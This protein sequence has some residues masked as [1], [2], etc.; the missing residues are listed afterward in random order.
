MKNLP[1]IALVLL[2]VIILIACSNKAKQEEYKILPAN[3]IG[4]LL[5][6]QPWI[7]LVDVRTYAE[8]E[9][10]YIEK[11]INL[12]L[13]TLESSA[14]KHLPD[15][16]QTIIVYCKT[17]KR[18]QVAVSDL[19]SLGYTDIIELEGGLDSWKGLLVKEE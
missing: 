11:A 13:D 16:E 3:E 17:G 4:I 14:K 12:P 1:K 18:S 10:G 15:K 19:I 2:V 7:T 8:Y 9:K 5:N 6:E